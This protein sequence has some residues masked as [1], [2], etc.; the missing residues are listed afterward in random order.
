MRILLSVILFTPLLTQAQQPVKPIVSADYLSLINDDSLAGKKDTG[1]NPS[2]MSLRIMH[3]YMDQYPIK[4]IRERNGSLTVLPVQTKWLSIGGNYTFSAAARSVNAMPTL[5]NQFVQGESSNGSLIWQGP[6]TNELFSYGPDVQDLEYDGSPY[7]YDI[8]GKLAGAGTGN[9]KRAAPYNNGIL[10]TAYMTGQSI[11]LRANIKRNYWEPRW[12][13]SLKASNNSESTVMPQNR[14]GSNSISLSAERNLK[15][16]SIAGSYSYFT[17][18][19]SNDNSNGFL[20]RVYQNA[21]LTPISFSNAQ[22]LT[23]INGSQRAYSSQADNPS[24]LLKGNGHFANKVQQT[25]SLSLQK[26]LEFFS[27]GIVTT[28]DAVDDNSNQSLPPGTAFFP[29]A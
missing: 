3:P 21:L 26:K 27:Y 23:L 7:P 24:F 14:N 19:F 13:F 20:N 8:N 28:L 4:L 12:A 16:F 11:S 18:R 17:S 6:E 1:R 15:T 9:G 5:Q 10:Q 29:P 22:S 2:A 25:G